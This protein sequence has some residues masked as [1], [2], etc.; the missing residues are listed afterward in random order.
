MAT[1]EQLLIF[2]SGVVYQ[3]RIFIFATQQGLRLLAQ[4]DHWYADGTVN[5]RPEILHQVYAIHAQFNGQVLPRVFTLL[6]NKVER[7]YN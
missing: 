7:T 2:D 5:V 4:S 6:P 1:G 3:E